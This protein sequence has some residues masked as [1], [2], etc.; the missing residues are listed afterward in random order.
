MAIPF[1]GVDVHRTSSDSRLTP[2]VDGSVWQ[3]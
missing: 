3:R 2:A 1:G